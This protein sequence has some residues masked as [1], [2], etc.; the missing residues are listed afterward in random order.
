MAGAD[1]HDTT[2]DR[3]QSSVAMSFLHASE[4]VM[5]PVFDLDRG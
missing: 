2:A 3:V 4:S 5:L 1:S